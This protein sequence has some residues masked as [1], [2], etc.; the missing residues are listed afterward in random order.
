MNWLKRSIAWCFTPLFLDAQEAEPVDPALAAIPDLGLEP[1]VEIDPQVLTATC[2][3]LHPEHWQES[4]CGEQLIEW[5]FNDGACSLYEYE[6][7]HDG[8]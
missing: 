7:A 2:A 8:D 6:Y 5:E 1:E 4:D 3:I